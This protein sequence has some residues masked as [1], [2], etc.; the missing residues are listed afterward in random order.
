[1]KINFFKFVLLIN[2]FYVTAC[3]NEKLENLGVIKKKNNQ[4][5]VS[6]KAP[7][8]MPPDMY[9]RPP[10]TEKKKEVFNFDED[11]EKGDLDDILANKNGLNAGTSKNSK[12]KEERI[13]KK[14]L[15]TKAIVT[16]K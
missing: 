15:N 9:L 12:L 10:K 7:L 16:L 13:I 5:S 11:E 8:E 2:M 14:I 4:Y 1:M 3:S 6:R